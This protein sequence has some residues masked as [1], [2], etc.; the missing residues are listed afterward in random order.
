M[1]EQAMSAGRII[2]RMLGLIPDN[3]V[4]VA[5]TILVLTALGTAWDYYY[6]DSWLSLPLNIASAI[7][8]YWI[9]RQALAREGMLAAKLT[10]APAS[11]FGVS[12][13]SG[14]GILF[15]FMLLI[16]PGILLTLRWMPAVPLVLG[17]ERLHTNDALGEAWERT[18]GHWQA[19]GAAYLLTLI[20]F[21]GAM[22]AYAWEAF[23]TPERLAALGAA[24]AL[25]N[26]WMALN[27]MLSVA[28][29][30][31]S[32]SRTRELEDVFA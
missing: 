25:L 12:V 5:I 8:Q 16:V 15:G 22:F 29:Y 6:P 7:A 18:R 10:G 3:A 9:V 13:V 2:G 23:E 32:A 14:I 11:Y 20:P 17:V 1:D 28:V 4:P 27:W 21:A 19:I 30:Q 24:N 26:L 31:G